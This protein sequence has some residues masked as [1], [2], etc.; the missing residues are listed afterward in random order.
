MDH[1]VELNREDITPSP[2]LRGLAMVA[3]VVGLIGFAVAAFM[4][5]SGGVGTRR[6][7]HAYLVSYAFYMSLTLGAFFFTFIQ[8]LVSAGWSV[9]VRRFAENIAANIVIMA[10]LFI[11]LLLGRHELFEWL[12]P[13]KVAADELLQHKA[14]YLNQTFFFVRIAIYF[15]AWIGLISFFVGRSVDQDTSKNWRSTVTMKKVA[16]PTT[17]IFALTLSFFSFDMLMSLS[18]KWFSTMFGVYYFSGTILSFFALMP[19]MFHGP[20]AMGKLRGL[21]TAHHYHD[22]GKFMFAFTVF[23]AYIAFSQFMLIWYANIPEETVWYGPRIIGEWRQMT[24]FL[25]LGHFVFP[26]MMLISRYPKRRPAILVLPALW[27]LA[28]HYIDCY[29]LIMPAYN[30]AQPGVIPFSFVDIACFVGIGGIFAAGALFRTMKR[31]L[32]PSG[33][34][35]LAESLGFEQGAG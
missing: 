13:A 3:L 20:Q 2:G 19:I 4:T 12:D 25:L 24:W 30:E 33:D 23:W 16:A 17:I 1:A 21:V 6:F 10:I 27:L 14:P 28:M 29:W 34:P 32:I 35:R 8:H 31:D 9:V 18:A 15:A 5:T 7:M 11:P 26:F 22:M